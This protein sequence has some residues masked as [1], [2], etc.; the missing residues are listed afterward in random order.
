MGRVQIQII[1]EIIYIQSTGLYAVLHIQIH[2]D[3]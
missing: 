1:I 2:S 3:L